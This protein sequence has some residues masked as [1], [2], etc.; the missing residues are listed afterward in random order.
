MDQG[1]RVILTRL[2]THPEKLMTKLLASMMCGCLLAAGSVAF[3][4]DMSRDAMAKHDQTMKDCMA[5]QDSSMSKDAAMKSCKDM[6][7]KDAMSK[8]E[9]SKDGMGKD[10]M[11]KDA[12]KQ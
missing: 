6:M 7:A 11:S 3:A 9:M 1:S 2:L 10:D 4:D 5:K 12:M 8:D